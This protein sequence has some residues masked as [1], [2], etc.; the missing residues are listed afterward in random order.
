LYAALHDWIT[1]SKH[2]IFDVTA[3]KKNLLIDV[4]VAL[5][6]LGYDEVFTFEL[7]RKPSFDQTDLYHQLSSPVD[8]AYRNLLSSAPVAASVSRLRRLTVGSRTVGLVASVLLAASLALYAW[9]PASKTLAVTGIVSAV[10]SIVSAL[11]PFLR[12]GRD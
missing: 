2:C 6:A 12:R 7:K 3:L 11:Y 5:L 10:A 9:N 4:A 8:Y 1:S